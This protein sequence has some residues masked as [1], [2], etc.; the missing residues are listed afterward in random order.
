MCGFPR[1]FRQGMGVAKKLQV[2]VI[3]DKP[4]VAMSLVDVLDE[5]GLSTLAVAA[6]FDDAL[7]M[8]THETFDLALI[9]VWLDG[10]ASYPLGDILAKR[11]IPFIVIGA[12][13]SSAEPSS[14]VTAPHLPKPLAAADLS[15]R[16]MAMGIP[17]TQ[18][19]GQA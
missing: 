6:S 17:R 15:A 2:L 10:T 1:I 12:A 8:C 14:F 4:L 19:A 16:L 7:S 18:M 3:E 5:L 13:P 11:A 9:D